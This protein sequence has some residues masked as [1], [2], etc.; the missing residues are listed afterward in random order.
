MDPL[1]SHAGDVFSLSHGLYLADT[2]VSYTPPGPIAESFIQ[3]RSFISGLMGPV[4]SGKSSAA[5]MKLMK[6]SLEQEPYNRVRYTRWVCI[7]NTYGELKST[8][9]KSFQD[10][11]PE[12]V[13]TFRW[14]DSPIVATM[15]FWLADKTRVKVEWLFMALD[16][17]DDLGKL[18]SL[19]ATGIWLN[20]ASELGKA[21]FDKST[22]RVGR[23]PP[24]KWGSGASWAGVIMD[25]NPP[26]DDHW[27]Y[28]MFEEPDQKAILETK[29]RL[30]EFG[31]L[32]PNQEYQRLYKQP[33]GLLYEQGEWK[34]N[35]EAENLHNLRGGVGYYWQQWANKHD[36]WRKVF[37]GGQY[38]TISTGRPVYPEYA[39]DI[40]CREVS[41]HPGIPILLGF[42]YGLTPACCI[43][44]VTPR[45]HLVVLD[46]LVAEDM[47]IAQFARDVVKPHLSQFYPGFGINAVGDPAGMSRSQTEER[48]CFQELLEAGIPA[49]PAPTN[50]FIA[51]REAVAKLLTSLIDGKP[52]LQ[53]SPKA[54]MVRKGFNGHYHFERLQVGGHEG[55]FKSV[56]KKND[57]S[58]VHDAL[59]YAAL[60]ARHYSVNTWS[61][62]SQGAKGLAPRMAI[63]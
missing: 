55:L 29:N 59:Q 16:R 9:I 47:G 51:R 30:V 60:Y 6:F 37:L 26:D 12:E 63:A 42:D 13:A 19:E 1:L 53:V 39:D 38:G 31:V 15:D 27:W 17:P 45:G 14:G 52:A 46:E 62:P 4:G 7:R 58:H 3:D 33:G 25:T 50:E 11:F 18:R 54:P 61:T 34:A 41:P 35:P 40:H 10:W 21:I 2:N 8:T 23:Y 44:Q 20:E 32:D 57:A 36:S 22:E 49:I 43:C 5:I 48:T 56:P 28:S 24:K